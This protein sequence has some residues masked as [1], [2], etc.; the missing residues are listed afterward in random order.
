M[1]LFSTTTRDRLY[2]VGLFI[3]RVAAGCFMLTHGLPKLATLMGT[4]PIQFADPFGVGQTPS[5]VLTVFAEV[6]C[7]FLIIIGLLT[8]I[9]AIPL[10]IAMSVAFFYIH[11]ADD[12]GTKEMA[13]LYLVIFVFIAI[14]GPGRYSIDNLISKRRNKVN[15]Y[16]TT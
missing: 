3:L 16:T 14:A 12:F 8:R 7:A 13:G 5:L 6:V 9:A 2:D 1:N 15:Y 4:E 10:I 11:M